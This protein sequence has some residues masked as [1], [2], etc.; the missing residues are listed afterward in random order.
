MSSSSK[1]F[2][3]ANTQKEKKSNAVYW[4]GT[5]SSNN[6]PDDLRVLVFRWEPNCNG[7]SGIKK[8]TNNAQTTKKEPNT[9]GGPGSACLSDKEKKKLF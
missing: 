9:N 7:P 2:L 6:A 8:A 5:G 1:D 4:T 3:N